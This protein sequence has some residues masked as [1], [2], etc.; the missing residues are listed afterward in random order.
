MSDSD[1]VLVQAIQVEELAVV[2]GVRFEE[3]LLHTNL[4]A[5]QRI[6]LECAVVQFE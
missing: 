1:V 3:L 2:G 4:F 6:H 5:S